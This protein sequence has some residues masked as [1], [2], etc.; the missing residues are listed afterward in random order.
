MQPEIKKEEETK[1]K[2]DLERAQRKGEKET[3]T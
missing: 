1:R 2:L 3:S